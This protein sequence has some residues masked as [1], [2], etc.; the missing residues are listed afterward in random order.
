MYQDMELPQRL[1]RLLSQCQTKALSQQRRD[2]RP[3][4][5]FKVNLFLYYFYWIKPTD[6][7]KFHHTGPMLHGICLLFIDPSHACND[8]ACIIVFL[9]WALPQGGH[10]CQPTAILTQWCVWHSQELTSLVAAMVDLGSFVREVAIWI[11]IYGAEYVLALREKHIPI[12]FTVWPRNY[13]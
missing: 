9:L 6:S 4:H 5:K 11:K 2:R 8:G 12:R 13:V 7:I 10:S 3:L 1:E